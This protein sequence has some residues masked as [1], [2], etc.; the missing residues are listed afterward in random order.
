MN[1]NSVSLSNYGASAIKPSIA[2]NIAFSGKQKSDSVEI[3]SNKAENKSFLNTVMSKIGVKTGYERD[4]KVNRPYALDMAEVRAGLLPRK[5]AA[6]CIRYGNSDISNAKPE[7][8]DKVKAYL[9]ETGIDVKDKNLRLL[10]IADSDKAR[11]IFKQVSYYDENEDKSIVFTDKGEPN[12]KIS[13]QY[14]KLGAIKDYDITDVYLNDTNE[15][16]ET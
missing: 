8:I 12:Y 1:I 5:T 6:L 10:K 11:L 15:W 14:D 3:R 4:M 13:Y 16:V 9:A 7:V 2:K